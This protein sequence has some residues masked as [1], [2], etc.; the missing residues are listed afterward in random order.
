MIAIETTHKW[1][2]SEKQS[3]AKEYQEKLNIIKVKIQFKID[4]LIVI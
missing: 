1:N 2:S 3:N 4:K